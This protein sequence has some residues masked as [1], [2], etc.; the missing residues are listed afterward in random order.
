MAAPTLDAYLDGFSKSGPSRHMHIAQTIRMLASAASEL[1]QATVN[2]VLGQGFARLDGA[3]NAGGD[4]QS[5]L[6]LFADDLFLAAAAR[7]GVDYYAS[8][9]RDYPVAL[10]NRSGI[11]LAVDPLDGSSG[12]EAN[13]SIGTIFSLLPSAATAAESFAQAG[14]RQLASG[15]FIY[16]P[17]LALALTLGDGVRI[18]VFSSR[19][20]AFLLAHEDV[21]IAAQTREFAI[22]ASNYRHWDAAVQ[23][24]VDDCLKGTDGPCAKDYNMRWIAS[25]VAES[26]RILIRGGAFLYP[27]DARRGY[28]Q[29]RLRLVYEASPIAMLVEQAGGAATDGV[30]RILDLTPSELHQ[31]TPLV[32][33]SA[34]EVETIA[35]YH[36]DPSAIGTRAPLFGNRGLLRA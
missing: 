10:G 33:G 3:M 20:G 30:R 35:R 27:G 1:R 36:A 18:F 19:T 28:H 31:R 9:E 22:N 11:A 2:G 34:R 26:Y 7:A 6:D 15:F 24:Y 29:G 4:A 17:Q 23:L 25:L 16:G 32:F 14:H 13:I 5:G 21:A 8:E 12:I